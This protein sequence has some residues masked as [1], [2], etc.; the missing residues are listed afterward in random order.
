MGRLFALFYLITNFIYTHKIY[1]TKNVLRFHT[2]E[3]VRLLEERERHKE[4][5]V[6]EA[7]KAYKS[8]LHGISEKYYALFRDV[9]N[10]LAMADCLMSLAV[11]SL[12][13]DFCKPEFVEGSSIS[14]EEGRHPII[15]Q[16][17]TEPVVPN[18]VEIAGTVPRTV[19]ISG[20][21]VKIISLISS[22][23]LTLRIRWAEN[24]LS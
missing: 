17:R 23:K 24:R 9:I 6:A 16:I 20:P 15:E 10:K 4:T 8:F 5:R 12:D 2:P 3:I 13:G 22:S 7:E 11:V 19:V 14:I 18:S 1:S 21:N